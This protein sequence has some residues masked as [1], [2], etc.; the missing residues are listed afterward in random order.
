MYWVFAYDLARSDF[1]RLISLMIGSFV[2]THRL[3][4]IFGGDFKT[5]A[6]SG[7]LFRAIFLLAI[8]NLSQDFY[9]FLWDGRLI[10]QGMSPYLQTPAA[11]LQAGN[12]IVP[13]AQILVDGM[14]G[15]NAGNFSNYPPINQLCFAIA[16]LFAG[17]SI[18]IHG[19]S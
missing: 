7:L 12:H 6:I 1:V 16:A 18:R 8:P 14:G 17:K 9:R 5:L 15:L 4:K 11:F 13:Q 2:L 10:V 19:Y 3:I